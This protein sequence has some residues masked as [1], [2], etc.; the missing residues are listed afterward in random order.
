MSVDPHEAPVTTTVIHSSNSGIEKMADQGWHHFKIGSFECTA[1]W[2]GRMVWS[3]DGLY[4]N[5]ELGEM[6]RLQEKY[7]LSVT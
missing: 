1:V 5:A 3:Y 7:G 4:P 6:A 2:D